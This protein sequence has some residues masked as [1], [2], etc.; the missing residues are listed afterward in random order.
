M[1]DTAENVPPVVEELQS[2]RITVEE[3]CRER[4]NVGIPL[5]QIQRLS[6][7]QAT[8]GLVEKLAHMKHIMAY[9]GGPS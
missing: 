9:Q 3:S 5:T 2:A 1:V 7:E 8:D 4:I 6:D